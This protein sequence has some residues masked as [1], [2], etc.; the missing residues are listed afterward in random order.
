V[1]QANPNE[2]DIGILK[3]V[4]SERGEFVLKYLEAILL[5]TQNQQNNLREP[6]LKIK[7]QMLSNLKNVSKKLF[8][9]FL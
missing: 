5:S 4:T 1:L 7:A 8:I 3:D 9:N 2:V 6:M